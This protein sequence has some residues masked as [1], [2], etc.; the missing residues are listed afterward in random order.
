MKHVRTWASIKRAL[1]G[2]QEEALDKESGTQNAGPALPST[3]CVALE[4]S[5]LLFGFQ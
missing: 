3:S 5:F 4:K 2:V 1:S